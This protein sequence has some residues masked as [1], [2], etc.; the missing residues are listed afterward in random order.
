MSH[1]NRVAFIG[2]GKGEHA[3]VVFDNGVMGCRYPRAVQ[4]RRGSH[5]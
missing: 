4:T 1:S 5:Q 3:I 2:C